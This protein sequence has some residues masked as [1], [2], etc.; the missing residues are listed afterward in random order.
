MQKEEYW[1]AA[2]THLYLT[3]G[4]TT[5]YTESLNWYTVGLKSGSS[6]STTSP[7]LTS[8]MMHLTDS[9]YDVKAPST[10]EASIPKNKQDHCVNDLTFN[11]QQILLS[12]FNKLKAKEYLRFRCICE[13]DIITHWITQPNNTWSGWVSTGRRISRRL[14]PQHE[15]K[16]QRGGVLHLGTINGKTGTPRCSKTKN[17]E[18]SDNNDKAGATPN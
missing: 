13:Q 15:Q 2:N 18:I 9:D 17:G 6:T 5:K 1:N 14:H 10:W 12:A 16:A 7:R 11:H 8:V 4:R 3:D